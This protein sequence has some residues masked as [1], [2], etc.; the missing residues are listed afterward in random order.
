MY[1][2]SFIAGVGLAATTNALLLP[3]DLPIADDT[4]T[5]LPVP[6]AID[7]DAAL[8]EVPESRAVDLECPGCL[9]SGRQHEKEIPSH[10]KLD[11]GVQPTDGGDRLTLNG[12]ELYPNPDFLQHTLMAP[13]IPNMV[14]RQ[15]GAPRLRGGPDRPQ[16]Y[17]PLGFA[18]ETGAV[19]TDDD[20]DLQ[21][22]NV[23]IQII[24]VGDVF[25]R[26]IP[27]VQVKLLKTPSNK[28]AIGTIDILPFQGGNSTD[29]K[30]ECSTTVC[31]WKT[32]F[33]EKLSKIFS[34]KGCGGSRPPPPPHAHHDG[35]HRHDHGPHPHSHPHPH[36]PHM[37][38]HRHG[39]A[40][41]FRIIVTHV[42]FP[43]LIGI[44]A[45]VSASLI[46]MMVGTFIVF[47]WRLFFRRSAS[48]SSH[49]C[50]YAH[51]AAKHENAADEEKSGLLDDQ[52][53]IEA[54]PAYM[55]PNVAVAEDKKAENES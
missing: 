49:R 13:V 38:H 55:E 9:R 43:V 6:I 52:E 18:M 50:R 11:F 24:E 47:L 10:L 34:L 42:L 51:K 29:N 23:E 35:E 26:G 17:Q 39:W 28:L 46:G 21:L 53:E 22:I 45:G 7:V 30:K 20:E 4:V 31:K 14:A 41:G 44:V 36:P 8:S 25:I 12:Y 3:P 54:P 1:L 19:A 48:R 37:G 40:H 5:T 16:R 15:V 32:L 2:R 33:F 27:N